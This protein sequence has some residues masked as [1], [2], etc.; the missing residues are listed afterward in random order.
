M[1]VL[2]R[3][4]ENTTNMM[5]RALLM[6][7]TIYCL[8][9]AGSSQSLEHRHNNKTA[10]ALDLTSHHHRQQPSFTANTSH[11]FMTPRLSPS[12]SVSNNTVVTQESNHPRVYCF[13][14]TTLSPR[15]DN[16][17]KSSRKQM[18]RCHGFN[19]WTNNGQKLNLT[20]MGH[21]EQA[22]A[23][24][25]GSIIW[26]T[27][28]FVPRGANMIGLM[29]VWVVLFHAISFPQVASYDWFLNIEVDHYLRFSKLQPAIQTLEKRLSHPSVAA[30]I[31]WKNAFIYNRPLVREMARQYKT[32]NY[33]VCN[34]TCEL[35][36]D[37]FFPKLSQYMSPP[38]FIHL[39]GAD[40]QPS[41][42]FFCEGAL[43]D[44][45]PRYRSASGRYKFTN[46]TENMCLLSFAEK[47]ANFSKEMEVQKKLC[48]KSM[49]MPSPDV[50]LFHHVSDQVALL[51]EQLIGF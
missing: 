4:R 41:D 2:W 6:L 31:E 12:S 36:Q 46:C 8:K 1:S 19:Y 35:A 44:L 38:D 24:G 26:V 34:H 5:F 48:E 17:M 22:A 10:L 45:L 42:P 25:D 40:A 30:I 3:E 29:P 43:F 14:F 20:M 7:T 47:F 39:K 11:Y 37:Q 33:Q 9:V 16:L 50:V 21:K 27:E 18:L 15:E 51:W 49:K 13:A 23:V 28:R 32:G